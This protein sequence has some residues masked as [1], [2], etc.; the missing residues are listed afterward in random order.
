LLKNDCLKTILVLG[1][2]KSATVLLEDL[3]TACK[4]N[5]WQMIVADA[6]LSLAASKIITPECARAVE[7]D[8]SNEENRFKLIEESNLVISLLPPALHILVAK[9]CLRAGKHLLTASYVDEAVQQLAGEIAGRGLL[10]L[11]E[12]GLDPGID[13]MSALKLINEVK[14]KGFQIDAFYSHCGGLIAPESDTNPWHYKISWNPRNIVRAGQAGAVYRENSETIHKNYKEIFQNNPVLSLKGLP[15]LAWYPNRDSVSY[16]QLYKL[17]DVP[18]FIRTTLRYSNFCKG[19]NQ[20]VQLG[21]TSEEDATLIS[22]C[23]TYGDWWR[24]KLFNLQQ[25]PLSFEQYLEQYV[26][27]DLQTLIKNQFEYLELN[28]DTLL[29]AYARC[30]AD[31]LQ[32]ILEAKL[33]LSPADKDLIVMAHE[34]D[35]HQD[36]KRMRIR[37]VLKV[38]GSDQIHTAMAKTVG[39]PLSIAAQL[40]LSDQISLRGLRIPVDSEIY[41]P[42]LNALGKKGI[43]FEEE[44]SQY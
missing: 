24:S 16:M 28:A 26:T 27:N 37:S 44:T 10:F 32:F 36:N 20:L 11:Y 18:T 5:H 25:K 17:P 22:G 4:I 14:D 23:K 30:S 3:Q 21:M 1:A 41:I 7:L 39:L 38:K 8:A 35:V 40:L 33:A 6:S 13:H 12:M 9:D 42:V 2:G 15:D 43:S 34:L 19:W 29:P 31:I